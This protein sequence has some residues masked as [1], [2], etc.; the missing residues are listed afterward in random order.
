MAEKFDQ[1][2][3]TD[4]MALAQSPAGQQLLSLLR[5][6]GGAT[7][8]QAMGK[9]AAGDLEGAKAVLAPMLADPRVQSLLGQLGGK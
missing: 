5:Q 1:F 4:M 2:S 7:V 3:M 8:Q 6:S 9:A